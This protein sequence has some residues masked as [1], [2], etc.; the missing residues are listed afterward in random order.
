MDILLYF[1]F[2][3]FG[4]MIGR[5]LLLIRLRKY[6][7]QTAKSQ[8]IDLDAPAKSIPIC[9]VEKTK[10]QL[11]LYDKDTN[12]FYCQAET[13]EEL[14]VNLKKNA[15]VDMALVVEHIGDKP[16]MWLFKDGKSEPAN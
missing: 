16:Y 13:I 7:I 4:W 2:F 5:E 14:A 9:I 1:V 12:K 11:Y 15:H 8:G 6:I 3:I 10:N